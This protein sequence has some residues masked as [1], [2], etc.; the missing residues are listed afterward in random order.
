MDNNTIPSDA[1]SLEVFAIKDSQYV[2]SG[3]EAYIGFKLPNGNFHF[4]SVPFTD[5]AYPKPKPV[6]NNWFKRLKILMDW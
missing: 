2:P 4:I 1:H 3:K 5:V 6:K